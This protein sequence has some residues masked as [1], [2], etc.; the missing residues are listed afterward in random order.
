MCRIEWR[1]G[2]VVV[3][4]VVECECEERELCRD[5]EDERLREK[6]ERLRVG[7]DET[8]GGEGS[9]RDPKRGMLKAYVW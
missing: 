7:G 4:V 8:G 5:G 6:R 1:L 9:R 3:V 2:D